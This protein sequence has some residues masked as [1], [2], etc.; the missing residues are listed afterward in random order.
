MPIKIKIFNCK[1][2][3]FVLGKLITK[4]LGKD[5]KAVKQFTSYR[6]IR[7]ISLSFIITIMPSFSVLA[8]VEHQ[9]ER[10]FGTMTNITAPGVFETQRRGVIT[11][12]SVV[13]RHKLMD[14]NLV[15][16]VP[17]SAQAGCGG[18]DMFAGSLS[19]INADQFVQLLR[20]VASNAKGYAFQL[21]LSAMC[22]KCS[23]HI[24]T[25]QKKVQQLNEYFGQSCQ[26]AQGIV[27]DSI[28]AFQLKGQSEAS[29]LGLTEGVGDV[30]TT[31][32]TSSGKNSYEHIQENSSKSIAQAIMGNLVWR[33]LK[34]N[35]VENWFSSGDEP[36]LEAIMSVTGSLIVGPLESA[37][38]NLGQTPKLTKLPGQQ[39]TLEDLLMGGEVT[40]YQC[41]D[42]DQNGCLHPILTHM[43]IEGL[44]SKVTTLLIGNS[45]KAGI[46]FKFAHNDMVLTEEE[47]SFM[48]VAPAHIGT[49]I[50]TL[51][52]INEG[53]ARSFAQ[54]AAPI[55]ALEL[56]Y[57]L[58]SDMMKSVRDTA[59]L[60]NHAYQKLLQN[61][62]D[63]IEI[64]ISESYQTLIMR[65]G[66]EQD[67]IQHYNQL[68]QLLPHKRYVNV[69][70]N[71]AEA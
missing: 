40:L 37:P 11:G 9:M 60:D 45:T 65:F 58:I 17:P 32:S 39:L 49:M 31:W 8:N 13:S 54:R 25:L 19:Y 5:A 1:S 50:R 61:E 43:N 10:L 27:N 47:K 33:A 15:S 16:F 69:S 44:S 70:I 12:G 14:T 67:I 62:L 57:R 63:R 23:Q 26:L 24:E 53:A 35:Q 22:E 55:I 30:F 36:L 68:L 34:N 2:K 21:A 3:W 46:I 51:S 29:L 52:A 48:A 71:L 28:G 59:S 41:D 7:V 38:D 4:H 20:S 18:I 6:Y 66:T 64:L 56:S 42:Y